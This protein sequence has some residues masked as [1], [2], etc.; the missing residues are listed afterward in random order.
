MKTSSSKFE[1]EPEIEIFAGLP[2]NGHMLTVDQGIVKEFRR[3]QSTDRGQK[4]Q[5]CRFHCTFSKIF[6]NRHVSL[7]W[8]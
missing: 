6:K 3:V 7:V 5:D 4:E 8:L 2:V 1:A